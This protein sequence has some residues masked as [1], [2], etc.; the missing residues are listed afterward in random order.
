MV[1]IFGALTLLSALVFGQAQA[2]EPI[3]PTN[4]ALVALEGAYAEAWDLIV[5]GQPAAA[6]VPLDEALRHAQTLGDPELVSLILRMHSDAFQQL[7]N[8]HLALPA[9]RSV[10]PLLCVSERSLPQDA[11]VKRTLTAWVSAAGLGQPKS[12]SALEGMLEQAQVEGQ[13]ERALAALNTLGE[14]LWTLDALNESERRHQEALALATQLNDLGQQ[15]A[16]R[17]GLGRVAFERGALDDAERHATEALTF[18]RQHGDLRV[19]AMALVVLGRV[20]AVKGVAG[21]YGEQYD[22]ALTLFTE[23]GD[24]SRQADVL[25]A[26]GELLHERY[27]FANEAA[28]RFQRA[29]QLKTALGDTHGQMRALIGLG[30]TFARDR[31]RELAEA[32]QRL[33]QALTLALASG[34]RSGE[35][36]ALRG[37]TIVERRKP[38]EE[39]S[40][41]DAERN[42]QR[43][44][45]LY[46][47]LGH[48]RGRVQT[49]LSLAYAQV[50][51]KKW[52]EAAQSAEL[53]LELSVRHQ[54]LPLAIEAVD[55]VDLTLGILA[56]VVEGSPEAEAVWRRQIALGVQYR[57]PLLRQNGYRSL[58]A[59]LEA[60]GRLPEATE[61]Q[62]SAVEDL[63]V[64]GNIIE[65]AQAH[66]RLA[67]LLAAQGLFPEAEANVLLAAEQLATARQTYEQL[68]ALLW[69]AEL[70]SLQGKHDEAEQTYRLCLNLPPPSY[71]PHSEV[72][73]RVE[74]AELLLARDRRAE[75]QEILAPCLTTARSSRG[76][77]LRASCHLALSAAHEPPRAARRSARRALAMAKLAERDRLMAEAL[78][79]VARARERL[80]HPRRA[81]RAL[82]RAIPL[83][84]AAEAAEVE[85][86]ALTLLAGILETRGEAEEAAALREEESA[87]RG[88]VDR[89]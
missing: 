68:S 36:A 88:W 16:A 6:M 37:L 51:L 55:S 10:S 23:L 12:L 39:Q 86:E 81:E 5:A 20:H 13:P 46:T 50:D 78:V 43:A 8:P 52:E 80:G 19:E 44:L 30:M 73:A 66:R 72:T 69:A 59:E 27:Y 71:A 85:A 2:A 76:T 21:N 34:S 75:A 77:S 67:E 18:G 84:E 42:A 79:S 61:S 54:L 49:L 58:A 89:E 4:P 47:E 35:A 11:C 28:S 7:P 62:R 15:G 48:P 70:Q 60:Q 40:L 41:V 82:R 65:T 9:L 87:L 32:E 3:D 45:Q 33:S 25:I 31:D 22:R 38:R 26:Q 53:A 56:R 64:Y 17:V 74:L 24:V 63:T 14:T 57:S 1:L 29:L 83:A